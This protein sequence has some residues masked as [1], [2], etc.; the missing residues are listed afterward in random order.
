MPQYY[1]SKHPDAPHQVR[2]HDTTL[3]GFNFQF[4]TD[5]GVFSKRG[6]DYGSI[7]LLK[8]VSFGQ[9]P[10]GPVLDLGCGY[11]PIGLTLAQMAPQR[12][13]WLS[14][15]NERALKLTQKNA[16]LNHIKN[17]KIL[18]SSIYDQIDEKFAMIAT[19]PPIRAGKKVVMTML[20][21]AAQHLVSGGVLYTVVRRK[22]GEPSA[23]KA[24]K[25]TYGNCQILK[26]DKGYYILMSKY[27]G[28]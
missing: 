17:V 28:A 15:V 7:A 11:G 4:L 1:Y 19:N 5:N 27:Q 16:D 22:Q 24:M 23:F 12:L 20:I 21:D 14:D 10:Q 18:S 13:V 2:R 3:N 25:K 26:R 6:I 8:Q 9:V